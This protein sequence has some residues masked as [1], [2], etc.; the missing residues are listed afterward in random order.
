MGSTVCVAACVDGAE[1]DKGGE[2]AC[3]TSAISASSVLVATITAA[4]AAD[5]ADAAAGSVTSAGAIV[6]SR[7]PG[8]EGVSSASSCACGSSSA[9]GIVI[10]MWV[11]CG[12]ACT[13][14]ARMDELSPSSPRWQPIPAASR[15][16]SLSTRCEVEVSELTRVRVRVK[17]KEGYYQVSWLGRVRGRVSVRQ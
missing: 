14:R 4:V 6:V 9:C 13:V 7:L 1:L 12:R 16:S 5:A 3:T 15:S 10:G 17:V 8:W 2:R 11:G